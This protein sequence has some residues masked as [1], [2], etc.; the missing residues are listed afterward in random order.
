MDKYVKLDGNVDDTF[1]MDNYEGQSIRKEFNRMQ[2][3]F[4]LLYDGE[5]IPAKTSHFRHVPVGKYIF[6][7]EDAGIPSWCGL[8]IRRAYVRS[9]S[10]DKVLHAAG[11]LEY[12]PIQHGTIKRLKG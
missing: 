2:G 10:S 9:E 8:Y 3:Q 11:L 1:K 4:V 5:I 6:L 12:N 7:L